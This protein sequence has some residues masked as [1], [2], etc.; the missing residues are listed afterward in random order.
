MSMQGIDIA[1]YQSGIDISALPIDFVIVKATQGNSYT[2]PDFTRA[3]D[4]TLSSGKKLG[5]Y[6]Y[7]GGQGSA[8]EMKFFVSKFNAYKGKAV[9]CLD[10]ESIQ[11]SEW[12]NENYL[13]QCIKEFISLTG[14]PPIVYASQSVFPWNVCSRNNCGTWVAQ[15]ASNNTTGLQASPWKEGEYNCTIRQYTSALRLDGWGGNL[16]GNKAYVDASGWDKYANPSGTA[17]PSTS[18]SASKSVSEL[19]S[20]VLAGK[21]GNG[22][23]RIN[24]LTSAGYDYKAVQNEVNK[25]LSANAIDT[26]VPAGKY[27]IKVNGLQIRTGASRQYPSVGSYNSGDTVIL[28]GTSIVADGWVWGRY[29]GSSSGKYRYIAVRSADGKTVYASK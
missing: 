16:D 19:A 14:I 4:Q 26:S 23:D 5:I 3:A 25:R 17:T 28:D 11:N 29:I 15:Y 27:T 13:E 2:N 6:H 18:T 21:W 24:K 22:Q 20:E 8:S 7:I 10:W 9:P 12:Q 1:S